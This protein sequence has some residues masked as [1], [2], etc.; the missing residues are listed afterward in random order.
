MAPNSENS[1]LALQCFEF[2]KTLATQ[3]KFFT[4][5]LTVD[6]FVFSL[7]TKDTSGIRNPILAPTV[8][9][10]KKTPSEIRRNRK[11][12]LEF[13]RRKQESVSAN[14]PTSVLDFPSSVN[15]RGESTNTKTCD[16][17]NQIGEST[18]TTTALTTAGEW[19]TVTTPPPYRRN[20]ASSKS[21]T[22][23]EITPWAVRKKVNSKKCPP[24][25]QGVL[26]QNCN[27]LMLSQNHVCTVADDDDD[28][29]N[30]DDDDCHVNCTEQECVFDYGDIRR[31]ACNVASFYC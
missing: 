24:D 21:D 4:F 27:E 8:R 13:L 20:S 25:P 22:D 30:D 26:C 16:S 29:E 18:P 31:Q 10:R 3:K 19:R 5:S 14:I 23:T 6:T 28:D 11:R 9:L 1:Y 17:L 7:D 2:C 15:P 12:R